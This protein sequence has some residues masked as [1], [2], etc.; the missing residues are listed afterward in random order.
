MPER[1]KLNNVIIDKSIQHL[2]MLI[3]VNDIMHYNNEFESDKQ[4]L[5]QYKQ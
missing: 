2:T 1:F 3:Y 5:S 4:S